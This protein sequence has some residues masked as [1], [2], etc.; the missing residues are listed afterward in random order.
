M[1]HR[2]RVKLVP[3]YPKNPI[4]CKAL[5]GLSTSASAT[6]RP[7]DSSPCKN[8]NKVFEAEQRPG[9]ADS[10]RFL[11]WRQLLFDREEAYRNPS[12]SLEEAYPAYY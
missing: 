11:S 6:K 2:T 1:R 8:Q 3:Q 9:P 7:C 12:Q 4:H 10:S 5:H